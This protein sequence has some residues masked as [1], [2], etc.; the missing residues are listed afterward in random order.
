VHHT[1]DT[2]TTTGRRQ[3]VDGQDEQYR[4]SR[5][6]EGLCCSQ[7][8]GKRRLQSVRFQAL[9]CW[10]ATAASTIGKTEPQSEMVGSSRAYMNRT[11]NSQA[12]HATGTVVTKTDAKSLVLA[13]LD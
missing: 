7:L 13:L 4:P 9:H 3:N 12:P 2:A 6:R 11:A 8:Q 5:F 10:D 1:T